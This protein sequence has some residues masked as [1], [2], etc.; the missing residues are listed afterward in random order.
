VST[1]GELRGSTA[2]DPPRVS[3]V[4]PSFDGHRGGYVPR[5]L[6]SIKRQ[7]YQDFRVKMV[8]GVFPQGRAINIGR[9]RCDG[10]IL[11]ILDDDSALADEH[12]LARLVATLDAD[13]RIGMAGAS[14]VVPPDATP[15]QRRAALQFPRLNTP[16]VDAITDS[17][18]ACHGGC[19]FP[20][21]V[22]DA[23]GGEREDLVRGL[24]PDLRVRL[25]KAG[26]RVVLAPQCRIHHPMPNGWRAL[27]RT[28]FRNGAGSA[29]AR[30][31]QPDSVYETHEYLHESDFQPRTSLGYRIAR[32]P[33]RLVKALAG[34]QFMRFAGYTAYAFGYAWGWL[35]AKEIRPAEPA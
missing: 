12:T 26:Y 6:E 33:F 21:A 7:T 30:K 25:R 1:T 5:L 9:S 32:Y 20:M 4:I 11:V 16:V 31:F 15:F 24:D 13:P 18:M 29:Y 27:L 2:S 8:I 10:E 35:T 22:F 14:I 28:Y 17:D 3:I 23:I 34:G 19:A